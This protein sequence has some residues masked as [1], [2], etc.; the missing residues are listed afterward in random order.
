MPPAEKFERSPLSSIIPAKERH[1]RQLSYAEDSKGVKQ[2]RIG[3][4]RTF[5]LALR[6]LGPAGVGQASMPLKSG[7]RVS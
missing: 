4:Y 3:L 6:G 2:N 1:D 7:H 5:C